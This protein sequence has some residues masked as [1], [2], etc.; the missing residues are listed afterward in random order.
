[1]MIGLKGKGKGSA[2]HCTS[3]ITD[4]TR[5]ILPCLTVSATVDTQ[6]SFL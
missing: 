2:S 1:M 5:I 3:T 6:Y 4:P